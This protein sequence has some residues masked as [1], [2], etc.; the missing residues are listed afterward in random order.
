MVDVSKGSESLRVCKEKLQCLADFGDEGPQE[1]VENSCDF[2]SHLITYGR[3]ESQ[4]C[5][6]GVC[7]GNLG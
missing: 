7:M 5:Y 2:G 1:A 6:Q 4:E 3:E